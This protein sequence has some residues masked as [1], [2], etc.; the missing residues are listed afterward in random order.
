MLCAHYAWGGVKQNRY[1]FRWRICVHDLNFY[2]FSFR[3]LTSFYRTLGF[4]IPLHHLPTPFFGSLILRFPRNYSPPSRHSCGNWEALRY[5]TTWLEGFYGKDWSKDD[6]SGQRLVNLNKVP[7]FCNRK[8][9]TFWIGIQFSCYWICLLAICS[10]KIPNIEICTLFYYSCEAVSWAL[11]YCGAL[12][13][14]QF[15]DFELYW[16]AVFF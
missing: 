15:K 6:P 12:G 16:G 3:S 13:F 2:L 8:L 5:M 4:E 9:I 14:L 7:N 1:L 11:L 10:C